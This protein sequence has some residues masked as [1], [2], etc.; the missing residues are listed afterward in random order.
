MYSL[1]VITCKV[2]KNNLLIPNWLDLH[3]V[4]SCSVCTHLQELFREIVQNGHHLIY[5]PFSKV[6]L[7]D[8]VLMQM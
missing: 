8:I 2:F 1:G 5:I 4:T 3:S 7:G 6:L